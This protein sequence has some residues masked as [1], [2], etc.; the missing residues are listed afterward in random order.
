[1]CDLSTLKKV[2]VHNKVN[3]K[4]DKQRKHVDHSFKDKDYNTTAASYLKKLHTLAENEEV[5]V[6]SC[7]SVIQ[8]VLIQLVLRQ[9]LLW[10]VQSGVMEL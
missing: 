2:R 7:R 9:I 4:K 8:L 10:K 1:M 6:L 5:G 3:E